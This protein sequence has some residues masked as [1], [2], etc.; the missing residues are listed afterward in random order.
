MTA[1]MAA[2]QGPP[3]GNRA[4][5]WILDTSALVVETVWAG[6][7]GE[8]CIVSLV[9]PTRPSSLQGMLE[10]M[11]WGLSGGV[12]AGERLELRFA[13]GRRL[14]SKAWSGFG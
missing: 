5:P 9:S 13:C 11:E 10:G 4:W 7:R 3:C 14:A 12:R 8:T 6:R 1:A 2:S